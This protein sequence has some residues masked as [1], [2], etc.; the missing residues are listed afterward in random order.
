M[1]DAPIQEFGH[2]K[3]RYVRPNQSW[4]C[5]RECNECEQG[6]D[7]KGRCSFVNEPCVPIRSVRSKKRIAAIGLLSVFVGGLI[8][9]FSA[10]NLLPMLSPGALSLS[11]G[12]VAGCQ[13]CHAAAGEPIYHW[14][15]KALTL[16]S[17][18]DDQQC[19]ACHEL[20]GNAFEA[21]STHYKNFSTMDYDAVI[22]KKLAS[23]NVDWK[24][25]LASQLNKVRMPTKESTSCSSCHREHKGKFH[26]INNFDAR[27]CHTCHQKKFDV[28]EESHPEYSNYP[29]DKATQIKFNHGA[30]LDKYFYDDEYIEI[31][32]EGCKQCHESDQTGEW[33]LSNNFEDTCGGCHLDQLLGRSR[34]SAKGLVVLA[35]PEL[36]VAAITAAGFS[37]GDWPEWAEGDV[38]PIM[39]LLLQY[40][41]SDST[42]GLPRR[43][44]SLRGSS[45]VLP[46]DVVLY[47]LSEASTHDIAMV[48][49]LA[50]N[51]KELFYDIQSGGA[52]VLYKRLAI[53]FNH[54]LDQPTL[55]RLISSLPRDT[56]INNQKEW[57]PLLAGEVSGFR[58]NNRL[59]P[60]YDASDTFD[61][62]EP[63]EPIAGVTTESEVLS[64][65]G[66][67]ASDDIFGEELFDESIL[68]EDESDILDDD[69]LEE[70][71]DDED[72]LNSDDEDDEDE[73][74]D[75]TAV[76]EKTVDI[77][78]K[79]S[80][81]WAT[82]GGWYRE[83]SNIRYRPVDHADPFLATWLEVTFASDE[84]IHNEIFESL[85]DE[86]SVGGCIKCHSLTTVDYDHKSSDV[87]WQ[88]FRPEDITTDFNRFSHVSH[89]SLMTDDGCA[90]CHILNEDLPEGA[91]NSEDKL[92]SEVAKNMVEK[93]F[94]SM[95]RSTCTQ[96]HQQGRAPSNCLTCHQYHAE[97]QGQFADK[98]ADEFST[99]S[100]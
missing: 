30:H 65:L 5:G 31:A 45:V 81:D 33:M 12:E 68:D 37:I 14:L 99:E 80:E 73:E 63:I 38:T 8:L 26:A 64:E 16:N 48:A 49:R 18:N 67:N 62:K 20:G 93:S 91:Q 84:V 70:D 47:D 77:N 27:R 72:I 74:I 28:I 96:C 75:Y 78:A 98:I 61:Y 53:A 88:S 44:K 87:R 95:T 85:S 32:P 92:D 22:H 36:D 59:I 89:F 23:G 60:K 54:T 35:I 51:I 55:N 34:G 39:K 66:G 10:K 90:S 6:P 29:N 56:L 19:L 1:K 3:S 86:E 15:Q 57:F 40:D 94:L 58:K 13:D 9:V 83:G 17:N 82:S 100:P 41:S 2:R 7:K 50:W 46:G 25:D 24:V 69:I 71:F 52:A 76:S 42:Q 79:N 11:H 21:H 4:L 97:R 43:T